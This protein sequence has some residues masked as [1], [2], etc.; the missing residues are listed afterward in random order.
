VPY[1]VRS[2]CSDRDRARI[3]SMLNCADE[4]RLINPS[5]LSLAHVRDEH[6]TSESVI[7]LGVY[8]YLGAR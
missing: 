1:C 7:R 3:N 8:T 4:Y 6:R 5:E 2:L